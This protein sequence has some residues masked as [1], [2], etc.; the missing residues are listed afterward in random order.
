MYVRMF[1]P[2]CS[3]TWRKQGQRHT[4]ASRGLQ[5]LTR[6]PVL[7]ILSVMRSPPHHDRTWKNQNPPARGSLLQK[8]R[9]LRQSCCEIFFYRIQPLWKSHNLEKN[10][11]QS[12]QDTIWQRKMSSSK[13]STHSNCHQWPISHLSCFSVHRSLW[14]ADLILAPPS[15]FWIKNHLFFTL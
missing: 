1:L 9:P 12:R 13:K 2:I 7:D 15:T 14:M 4:R 5:T 8:H 3:R 10:H 6:R 11:L